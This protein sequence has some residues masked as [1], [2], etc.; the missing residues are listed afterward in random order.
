MKRLTTIIATLTILLAASIALA[1]RSVELDDGRTVILKDDK[2]WEYADDRQDEEEAQADA[3][4][5]PSEEQSSEGEGAAK[6][7]DRCS[8][9]IETKTDRVTGKSHT[10]TREPL[11]T[12][13]EAKDEGIASQLFLGNSGGRS[14]KSSVIW[15]LSV[16]GASACVDDD[17]KAYVLFTDG[18]RLSVTNDGDYNCD[19]RFVTYYGGMFGKSSELKQLSEKTIEVIRV[20]TRKGSVERD[21][22]S[23][24]AKELRDSFQCMRQAAN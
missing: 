5:E 24:Q 16:V 2:T 1:E 19:R 4:A 6:A 8:S 22:S 17:N 9:L 13:N 10:G 12:K 18:S 11:I 23:E 21:L 3:D 7:G 14:N 20:T 15:A